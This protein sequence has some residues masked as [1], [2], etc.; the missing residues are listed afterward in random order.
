MPYLAF[1]NECKGFL[2]YAQMPFSLTGVPTCFNDITAHEIG[3]LK[4]SLFQLFV[5]DS[6]MA[7]EEFE[8]HI[9]D[10]HKLLD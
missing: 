9:T 7:G 2:T 8:Q 4:D 1:Y 3:D 10:L 5:N 6:G